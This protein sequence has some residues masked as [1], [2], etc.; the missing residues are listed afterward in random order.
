MIAASPSAVADSF[1]S[2]YV[3]NMASSISRGNAFRDTVA[4]LLEAAGFIV[5]TEVRENCKKID[6]RCRREDVDGPVRYADYTGTLTLN[7]CR[8]FVTDYGSLVDAKLAD[9]AWLIS[10]R[11]V[12]PDGRALVDAKS[13]LKCMTFAELQ[14]RL[15]G[16][17]GYLQDL[18]FRYEADRIADWH[19]PPH[20]DDA[21]N[22]EEIAREW[23]DEPDPAPIAIVAGY[24]KG[25]STFARHLARRVS[26]AMH[27]PIQLG[28]LQF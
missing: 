24:L 10:R 27:R 21:L 11:D 18:V 4:S 7:E 8:D 9:R 23:I 2:S 15:M 3:L 26:R 20:T 14:R 5:E 28:V 1:C 17:D 25:K 16:V 13:N 19:V 12:S 22:L 6:V